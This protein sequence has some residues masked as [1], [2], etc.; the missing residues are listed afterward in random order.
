VCTSS[1][2]ARPPSPAPL[3]V[4]GPLSICASPPPLHL[5]LAHTLPLSGPGEKL[6]LPCSRD[7]VCAPYWHGMAEGKGGQRG[8]PQSREHKKIT[9]HGVTPCHPHSPSL[10]LQPSYSSCN[11]ETPC[12]AEISSVP[13][14]TSSLRIPSAHCCLWYD[15]LC[16]FMVLRSVQHYTSAYSSHKNILDATLLD[17]RRSSWF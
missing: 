17:T 3:Q 12:R 14:R 1:T 8:Q 15:V 13:S 9:S 5:A 16:W 11:P 2:R 7:E 4:P 10:R 6:L